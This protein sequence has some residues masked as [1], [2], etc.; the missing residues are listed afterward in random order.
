M[1]FINRGRQNGKST[2]LIHTAYAT[3]TPIIVQDHARK[4]FLLD[5]AK[6][7]GCEDI[8]VFDL[9][10]WLEIK[11]AS[12]KPKKCLIDE[13]LPIIERALSQ[14]LDTEVLAVT[15]TLPM[16][17]IPKQSEAKK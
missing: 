14:A 3:D 13:A 11:G 7:L 12:F 6:E 17:E 1:K 10:E 16:D 4:T 15:F 2:I 5:Q 8:T 9:R